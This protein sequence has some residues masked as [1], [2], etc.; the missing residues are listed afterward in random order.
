[1]FSLTAVPRARGTLASGGFA[2]VGRR[3]AMTLIEIL[4]VIAVIGVLIG[5]LLPA[6]Q[7]ARSAARRAQCGN[8]LHQIGLAFHHF[9]LC[10]NGKIPR[11][12]HSALAYREAPWGYAILPYLEGW[13]GVTVN[14]QNTGGQLS[15]L[16][17][18][19][20][21]LR[22][23]RQWSYGKNV[24][25]ELE[26]SETGEVAGVAS[27]PTFR[28]LDD[29]PC[30]TQ[31]IL[32][33]EVQSGAMP[34]HIMAHYWYLGGEVEVAQKRHETVSN[35]LWV[36]AHVSGETFPSTFELS[37]NLDRWHPGKAGLPVY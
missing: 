37:R 26:A 32:V 27:G 18:C 6:V 11:S 14:T 4:V 35:F 15:R 9:A 36:D 20:S 13:N 30:K 22:E 3:Q 33:G 28:R 2:R 16:Y 19:P 5:I 34:D 17:R 12:S 24:W 1:M 8:N 25:F 23:E 7:A 31:T 29:I 21:D 10:Y